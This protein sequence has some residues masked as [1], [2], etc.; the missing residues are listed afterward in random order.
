ML[1]YLYK[2]EIGTFT[3]RKQDD[4][5]WGLWINNDMLNSYRSPGHAADAVNNQ[6]TGYYQ[7]DSF[8]LVTVPPDL[9]E[10]EKAGFP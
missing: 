9:S 2:T 5:L 4:V 6:L 7:W 10:W 1:M 3:I 8:D